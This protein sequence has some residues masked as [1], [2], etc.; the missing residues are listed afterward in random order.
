MGLKLDWE[1]RTVNCRMNIMVGR[2]MDYRPWSRRRVSWERMV[3]WWRRWLSPVGRWRRSN[4]SG[5]FAL[6]VRP[7]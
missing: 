7:R 4:L 6:L 2:M 3:L 5:R 1:G